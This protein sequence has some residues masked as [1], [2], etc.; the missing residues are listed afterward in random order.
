MREIVWGVRRDGYPPNLAGFGAVLGAMGED[1]SASRFEGPLSGD[2]SRSMSE[3]S[4]LV[5]GVEGK[6]DCIE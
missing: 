5:E 2:S 3:E 1:T 6:R 4:L